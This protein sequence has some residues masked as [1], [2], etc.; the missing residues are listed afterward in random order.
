MIIMS[1]PKCSRNYAK[2]KSFSFAKDFNL[3][4]LDFHNW[5]EEAVRKL[6]SRF[7]LQG[8]CSEFACFAF[9]CAKFM[10]DLLQRVHF[11][12][13]LWGKRNPSLKIKELDWGNA[14]GILKMF[15][16]RTQEI[17]KAKD[18]FNKLHGNRIILHLPTTFDSKSMSHTRNLRTHEFVNR[19]GSF[20]YWF[21]WKLFPPTYLCRVAIYCIS[22]TTSVFWIFVLFCS[23]STLPS[24]GS[25]W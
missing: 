13:L 2:N 1:F 20:P 24:L 15:E 16:E 10:R 23:N 21:R 12:S 14:F 5:R 7:Y 3:D 6:F 8:N 11:G 22:L 18:G 19:L 25:I 17:F 9:M 4:F